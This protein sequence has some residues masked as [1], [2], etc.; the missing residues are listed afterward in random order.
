M[1]NLECCSNIECAIYIGKVV[2]FIFDFEKICFLQ[3]GGCKVENCVDVIVNW[4]CCGCGE[5]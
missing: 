5:V 2:S 3:S 1:Y 4:E